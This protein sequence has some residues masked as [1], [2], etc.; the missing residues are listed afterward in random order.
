MTK[1]SGTFLSLFTLIVFISFNLTG[2]EKTPLDIW[3]IRNPEAA[4]LV[5][6]NAVTF[7][8]NRYVAVGSSGKSLFSVDAVNWFSAQTEAFEN[9]N[10]VAFGGGMFIAVGDFGALY[11]SADGEN[12]TYQNSKG[13]FDMYAVCYGNGM[14]VAV[15]EDVSILTST[16]AVNWSHVTLGDM[17]LLSVAYGNG[18]FVAGGG[19]REDFLTRALLITSTNGENWSPVNSGQRLPIFD[20]EYGNGVFVGVA[21]PIGLYGNANARIYSPDGN[22]WQSQPSPLLYSLAF[23]DNRFYAAGDGIYSSSNGLTWSK[24]VCPLGVNNYPWRATASSLCVAN[25]KLLTVAGTLMTGVPDVANVYPSP[26]WLSFPDLSKLVFAN[27]RYVGIQNYN[28]PVNPSPIWLSTNGF[29]WNQHGYI[30]NAQLTGIAYASNRFV[31]VGR[32]TSWPSEDQIFVSEDLLQWQSQTLTNQLDLMDIVY[33]NGRFVTVGQGATLV[34]EDGLNW[35]GGFNSNIAAV[36]FEKVVHGSNHFVAMGSISWT[37]RALYTSAD[38]LEWERTTGNWFVQD[39][40]FGSGKFVATTTNGV[41]LSSND[42]LLWSAQAVASSES[43]SSLT[44]APGYFAALSQ[45]YK[46]W[47]SKNG[48]QWQ[49]TSFQA[50]FSQLISL[51]NSFVA[52]ASFDLYGALV[53]CGPLL[54][55]S[56]SFF[57]EPIG[58]SIRSGESW[59]LRTH[60]VG[61]LPIKYQWFKDGQ[62][63]VGATNASLL[64]E[65]I[66]G[67]KQ[68]AYTVMALNDI[69]SVVSQPAVVSVGSTYSEFSVGMVEH[70]TV[71]DPP[72][73]PSNE[74]SIKGLAGTKWSIQRKDN[75]EDD[76]PW[77]SFEDVFLWDKSVPI[78]SDFTNRMGAFRAVYQH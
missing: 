19:G 50:N 48:S 6:V 9:L 58:I 71:Y 32:K 7:G 76:V 17:P 74:I 59:A 11:T 72:V 4:Q 66:N 78:V 70:P 46:L 25:N 75:L 34:S 35:T 2:A 68:G 16:D 33:G 55:Q 42:G 51:T 21:A 40:V 61:T 28:S 5:G 12:W 8:K 31:A 26:D 44:S 65:N 62:T 60:T 53:E 47:W 39:L 3:H 77:R 37:N 38:G 23:S 52:N 41:V 54:P 73:P 1:T 20:I 49:Q 30:T 13:F 15:G 27:G 14:F 36:R 43:L 56:P 29:Q 67:D 45:S 10:A 64:L 18:S 22:H 24:N 57:R 69:G 63:I